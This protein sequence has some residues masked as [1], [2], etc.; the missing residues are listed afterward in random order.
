MDIHNTYYMLATVSELPLEHTFFRNH[1]FPTNQEL[2]IFGTAKVLADYKEQHNRMAPFVLPRVGPI[3]VG[4]EGFSTAELEPANIS[5]SMPITEDQLK[6]RG[7]GE[8]LMSTLTPE[9]RSKRLQMNDLSELSARISR[10]EEWLAVQTML[11]NG[12]VMKHETGVKDVYEDVPVTFYEGEENPAAYK[13]TDGWT[14]SEYANNGW[15]IG[16]WYRDLCN[17]I[18]MLTHKGLPAREI[19]VSTDVGEFL[20]EDPWI[21]AMLD[22]RRVEMGRLAP[23]ELT[24]FVTSLG[25]INFDGRKL[26][27]LVSDGTYEDENG[28]DKPYID[29]ETVL[30]SAPGCGKGLYGG[31]TQLERD[32]E[33]HTYAG[34]RVP[35]YIFTLTP[36]VKETVLTSK[37]LFVPVRPNP[38]VSATNVLTGN[39]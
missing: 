1:F 26:D 33:Y 31:V 8:S 10:R 4:R 13:V 3:A 16:S 12:C 22:N 25:V 27:V 36:P 14:H 38:W 15:K 34:M 28:E 6:N 24:E 2:D 32:G 37:P 5:V 11:N 23:E 17:M 39:P 7:F 21:I 19:I 20:M 29:K 18:K 30:V 35:N 9:D